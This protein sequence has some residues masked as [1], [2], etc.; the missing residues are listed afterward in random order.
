M[1]L[2]S[3]SLVSLYAIAYSVQDC[4][5]LR[6][7]DRVSDPRGV[8]DRSLWERYRRSI[9]SCLKGIMNNAL[10]TSLLLSILNS[11]ADSRAS[12]EPCSSL[13]R[14][15]YCRFSVQVFL[16]VWSTQLP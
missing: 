13:L 2:H 3:G 10:L 11:S 6:E 5:W 8:S 7:A 1:S 16:V 12:R 4:E 14:A 15:L 9:L